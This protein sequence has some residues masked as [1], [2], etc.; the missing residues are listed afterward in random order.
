MLSKSMLENLGYSVILAQDGKEAIEIYTS[1]KDKID[2]VLLDM[3]MPNMAG[4]ETFIELLKINPDIKVL[5]SSGFSKD[6]KANEIIK[7]GVIGF[8]QKPFR[9]EELSVAINNALQNKQ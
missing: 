8:I 6:E 9:M 7:M 1:K 3:I 2:L 4:K 5:L